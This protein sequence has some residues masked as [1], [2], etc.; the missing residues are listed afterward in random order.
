M[1]P[2]SD[3]SLADFEQ[4]NVAHLKDY[5]AKC[6]L[7]RKGNKAELAA[8]AYSCH[9]MK[10]PL[11][12]SLAENVQQAFNDYQKTLQV[13]DV[14][15]P[16]PLKITTGWVGEEEGIQFWPAP[17]IVDVVDYFRG[18]QVDSAKM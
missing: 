8:L 6:G 5:L 10:K 16:D 18:Q 15:I 12:H 14:V 3:S 17:T 9:V 2:P 1:E 11:T 13:K 4:W 7:S